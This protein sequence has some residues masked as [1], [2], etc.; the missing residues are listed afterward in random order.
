MSD[1][2]YTQE[3]IDQLQKDIIEKYFKDDTETIDLIKEFE[4][5]GYEEGK[6]KCKGFNENNHSLY[7]IEKNCKIFLNIYGDSFAG[8]APINNNFNILEYQYKKSLIKKA[9][10]YSCMY[11]NS[12][13]AYLRKIIFQKGS[14]IPKIILGYIINNKLIL[15]HRNDTSNIQENITSKYNFLINDI[16]K[17]YT[18]ILNKENE[19]KD[20]SITV[21]DQQKEIE[22]LKSKLAEQTKLNNDICERM[23]ELKEKLLKN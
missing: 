3:E 11:P 2:Y 1:L 19:N 4:I 8:I 7:E 9:F 17:L 14:L 18:N 20:L 23:F 6:L 10:Y 21:S 16:I 22:D 15:S 13:D 12:G 5:I